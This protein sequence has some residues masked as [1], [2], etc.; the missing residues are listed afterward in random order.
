MMMMKSVHPSHKHKF[1]LKYLVFGIWQN[2]IM[3]KGKTFLIPKNQTLERPFWRGVIIIPPFNYETVA[4]AVFKKRQ[5]FFLPLNEKRNNFRIHFAHIIK[6]L[7]YLQHRCIYPSILDGQLLG[8][9]FP[10]V[11][12]PHGCPNY[13]NKLWKFQQ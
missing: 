3:Y 13:K 7:A 1:E 2:W 6:N 8:G 9:F 4:I 11:Y 5:E 12:W 10:I